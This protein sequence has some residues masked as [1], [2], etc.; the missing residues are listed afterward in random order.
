MF[1]W[2]NSLS[3]SNE[4]GERYTNA[5]TG[6]G[7]SIRFAKAHNRDY[8][9]IVSV[10]EIEKSEILKELV[11]YLSDDVLLE[12]SS[13]E[14]ITVHFNQ[15]DNQQYRRFSLQWNEKG[16]QLVRPKERNRASK[17]EFLDSLFLS[18]VSVEDDE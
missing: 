5:S 16:A 15:S 13:C 9:F 2:R 10:D 6:Q 18:S 14:I 4:I 11:A 8:V 17:V 7:C 12:Y 3:E 1:N